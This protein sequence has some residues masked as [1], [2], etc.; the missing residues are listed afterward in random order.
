[1]MKTVL[2]TGASGGIGGAV[3]EY[4]SRN[5]I[6][7]YALDLNERPFNS[8]FVKFVK[9]DVTNES[10]IKRVCAELQAGGVVLDAIINVAGIFLIDSFIEVD[11]KQLND[12]FAVNFMGTVLVNKIFYPLLKK[13]GRVIITTSEVAPLDPMPF[14]GIYNVTKT[15]LDSYSQALRQELNLLGQKVITVR[16]GAFNTNLSQ[17]SLQKTKEL[18]DKT[19]L[20]KKQSKNFYSIV[21]TFMGKPLPPEKIAKIYFKAVTVSR[22]KLIYKKHTN[23]LLKL[24]NILPKRLQC[25]IIKKLLKT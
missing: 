13:D 24:L 23:K 6:F 21:K 12:I 2:V 8:S 19:V 18:T 4:L 11:N 25:F 7:V 10:D 15:A 16:P 1:M 22:P 17:G 5:G 9:M 3:T 14:N 20:Y